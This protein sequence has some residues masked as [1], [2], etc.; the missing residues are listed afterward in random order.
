MWQKL[1]FLNPE[2]ELGAGQSQQATRT[3]TKRPLDNAK[4]SGSATKHSRTTQGGRVP[5]TM[6][7]RES[8]TDHDKSGTQVWNVGV[9]WQVLS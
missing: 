1:G 7:T 2:Q 9:Q 8:N 4:A 6:I 3:L 5:R